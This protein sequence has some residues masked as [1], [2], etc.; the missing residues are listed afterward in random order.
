MTDKTDAHLLGMNA[1][2]SKTQWQR[3]RKLVDLRCEEQLTDAEQNELI[4]LSEQLE[5]ANA[6]RMAMLAELAKRRE[7]PLGQLMNDLGL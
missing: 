6:E 5:E 4:K 2:F 1:G 3:Y 7:V